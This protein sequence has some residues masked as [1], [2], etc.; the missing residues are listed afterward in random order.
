G[1]MKGNSIKCAFR[2]IAS[3]L[4]ALIAANAH[5]VQSEAPFMYA[6]R[7][8]IAGQLTGTIAPDPDGAGTLRLLATRN[9]YNSLGQL[10]IVE[11][12][13]LT[14]WPDDTIDP[15]AWGGYGFSGSNIFS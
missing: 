15:T 12:G 3:S 4:F 14:S 11:T 2:L 7:Y 10:D 1:N 6:T 9:H 8:N 13:Q 5:A